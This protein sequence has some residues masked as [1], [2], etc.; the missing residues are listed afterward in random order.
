MTPD[1]RKV[2]KAVA[3]VLAA[4]GITS[5][6]TGTVAGGVHMKPTAV[7]VGNQITP[8]YNSLF[9]PDTVGGD[10]AKL[11]GIST[12]FAS[13]QRTYSQKIMVSDPDSNFATESF[14]SVDK[15]GNPYTLGAWMENKDGYFPGVDIKSILTADQYDQWTQTDKLNIDPASLRRFNFH[16]LR[17][18]HHSIPTV[19]V[20]VRN[21]D[22]TQKMTTVEVVPQQKLKNE[23][24]IILVMCPS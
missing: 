15:D 22:A 19:F 17:N 14:F 4:Q 16:V 21:P 24:C 2:L 11:T 5:R 1:R 6:A 7:A 23:Y 20:T 8:N 10:G 3:A 12:S 13:F 9:E 18:L